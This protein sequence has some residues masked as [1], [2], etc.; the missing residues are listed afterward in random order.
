MTAL[1]WDQSGKR[2]YETGVDRGVLYSIH[3]AFSWSGL[4]SVTE[5]QSSQLKQFFMDGIIYQN[6]IVPGSY[7][8]KLQA[9]TYP[10]ELETSLGGVDFAPGVSA[11]D[12][13]VQAFDLSYRTGVGND[14]GGEGF[15]L[16]LVWGIVATPSDIV[17]NS[18]NDTPAGSVFEFNLTAV[19]QR[20]IAVRPTA[21][22]VVDSRLVD[23]G[24]L[25]TIE[26]M[27][28]G[29]DVADPVMHT[30]PDFATLVAP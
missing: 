26:E 15:K 2:R 16:H 19:P 25:T 4:I 11:R 30:L 29:T 5:S 22:V 14:V 20:G 13:K 27:L 17:Y 21:H 3:G 23:S 28:Y 6:T 24:T 9:Y 10:D 1:V 18:I 8:A 12:Q 7:A